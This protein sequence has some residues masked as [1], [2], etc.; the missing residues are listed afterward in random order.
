MIHSGW[1]YFHHRNRVRH[2]IEIVSGKLGFPTVLDLPPGFHDF[3]SKSS[4]D[5]GM[6]RELIQAPR[7]LFRPVSAQY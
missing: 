7:D 3:L 2:G 6:F 1:Q 4:L 5:L